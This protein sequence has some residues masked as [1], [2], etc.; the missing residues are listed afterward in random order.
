MSKKRPNGTG[1]VSLHRPTNLWRARLPDGKGGK[2]TRY[3]KTQKAALKL[4]EDLRRRRD[5]GMSL[6]SDRVTVAAYLKGWLDDVAVLRVRGRTLEGYRQH[7]RDHLAPFFDGV[8]MASLS[9]GHVQKLIADLGRRGLSPST[10]RRVHATLR[11]ALTEAVR[12]GLVDRNVAK[13]V[14]LPRATR[15]AVRAATDA[16]ARAIQIAVQGDRL[17]ALFVLALFSGLRQGEL[18]GLAWDDLDLAGGTLTVRQTLTSRGGTVTLGEPKTASSKRTVHIPDAA[19]QTLRRHKDAQAFEAK[20]LGDPWANTSNLVFVTELGKP[21]NGTAV[22][23]KFQDLIESAGL[24]DM[25]FHDLRHAAATLMLASGLDI[26]IVSE[27]LGHANISQT[28]DIYGHISPATKREAADRLDS[29]VR[30]A[31]KA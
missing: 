3:A 21:L 14:T 1:S 9:M 23:H 16:D 22:T 6:R 2:I 27:Q 20:R 15:P 29:F 8:P 31:D 25:R 18:L 19:L 10:I 7:V 30:G 24:P 5:S 13:L 17:E 28:G 11:S 12:Q 4:L 26:K